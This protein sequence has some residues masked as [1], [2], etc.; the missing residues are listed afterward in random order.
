MSGSMVSR[1]YCDR[2]VSSKTPP[3]RRCL[4][5]PVRGSGLA[6]LD[7]EFGAAAAPVKHGS[8]WAGV[9]FAPAVATPVKR[10]STAAAAAVNIANC[11]NYHSRGTWYVL[12]S[13]KGHLACVSVRSL[14]HGAF[15]GRTWPYSIRSNGRGCKSLS[16]FVECGAAEA[17]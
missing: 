13:S 7:G 8:G 16:R 2:D 12:L 1:C 3:G 9:S 15:A 10:C 4:P 11:R 17:C 5:H 14:C 6:R